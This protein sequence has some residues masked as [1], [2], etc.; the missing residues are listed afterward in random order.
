MTDAGGRHLLKIDFQSVNPPRPYNVLASAS[1]QDVN[2]Q[3]WSGRSSLLVHPADLY[4]GI[5][6]P[7][8][9]VQKGEKIAVESIVT[10]LDGKLIAGRDVEIKAVLKDWQYEAGTWKEVTVDEQTCT[11]KSAGSS[12][13]ALCG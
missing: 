2:R 3:T 8:A 9:F 4:V 13:P 5:K 11:V 6:T 10:D 1:V 7:R 12:G